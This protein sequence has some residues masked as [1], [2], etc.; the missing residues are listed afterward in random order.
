MT[1]LEQLQKV[2]S[3]KSVKQAEIKS[4]LTGS[5]GADETP[6]DETEDKIKSLEAEVET[7]EKNHSRISKLIADEAQVTEVLEPITSKKEMTV[8]VNDN[9]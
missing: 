3:T 2:Q 5:I 6:N 9:F 4:L 7:L 8:T 1:L